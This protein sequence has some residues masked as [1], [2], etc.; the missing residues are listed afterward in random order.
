MGGRRSPLS[1]LWVKKVPVTYLIKR[2]PEVSG[3][4]PEKNTVE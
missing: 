3:Q 1:K 4:N 2:A